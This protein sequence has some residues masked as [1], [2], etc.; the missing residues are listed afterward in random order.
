MI[1]RNLLA[2]AFL[3]LAACTSAVQAATYTMFRDPNCGCCEHWAK[4][5]RTELET[6]VTQQVTADMAAVKTDRGVPRQLWSCHTMVVDGYVIEG[7]VPAA[8]VARL[9][10]ERPAGVRGLAVPGMP[11][12][13]PGMEMGDRKQPYQVIAFG[14][15]GMTVFASYN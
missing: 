13:S 14:D 2:P 1:F 11:V 15:A 7:H 3:A 12:G 8:D 5:V 4:H 6:E 9:L 10:E